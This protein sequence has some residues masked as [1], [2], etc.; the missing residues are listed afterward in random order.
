MVPRLTSRLPQQKFARL[1]RHNGQTH[2]QPHPIGPLGVRI[3]GRL[4]H[5]LYEY[6]VAQFFPFDSLTDDGLDDL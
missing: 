4:S 1:E 6:L 5:A 3:V 2:Q